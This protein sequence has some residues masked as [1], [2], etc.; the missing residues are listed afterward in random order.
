MQPDTRI[1]L[2]D[3]LAVHAMAA[4]AQGAVAPLQRVEATGSRIRQVDWKRPS[5]SR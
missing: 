5:R 1:A 3:A 4:I 2:A